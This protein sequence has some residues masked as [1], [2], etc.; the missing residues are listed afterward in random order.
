[1]AEKH[2]QSISTVLGMGR[3][4]GQHF[5]RTKSMR[6]RNLAILL[7]SLI[8]RSDY[9]NPNEV[10]TN[11]DRVSDGKSVKGN[12]RVVPNLML[13]NAR[14]LTNKVNEL[15]L[16]KESYR[17]DLIFVTETWLAD[18]VPDEIVS[19]SGLNIVRRD[20]LCGRGGG[21]A[22]Y[23]NH[24]IPLKIRD[25]LND[26]CFECLWVTIRPK[27]LPRSIS[28]IALGCVYLPPSLLTSE[29]ENFYD[30]FITCYDKLCVESPNTA[31]IL[32]GD[33]NP[34]S[35]GFQ[36]KRL[37]RHCNLKQIVMHP[38]RDTSTLDL[39]FTNMA[40]CYQTPAIL[41]PLSTSD[42]N[43]INWKSKCNISE[44]G[45]TVKIKVRKFQQQQLERFDALLANCD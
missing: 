36:Q 5:S 29:I 40:D 2:M 15:E 13:T 17:A 43:I 11:S 37:E 25:D 21:V 35:N 4:R 16:L 8:F 39:I 32:G 14:S 41:A 10:S 31:I 12:E 33:F 45:N 28:R 23:V 30:Y 24:D 27:W 18:T 42:H 26:Q 3:P 44:K 34:A 38:T 6:T 20:R 22:I 7:K 19:V 9:N 1:M